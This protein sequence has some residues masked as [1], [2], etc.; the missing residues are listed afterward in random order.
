LEIK[1]AINRL[2]FLI[3]PPPPAAPEIP[4]ISNPAVLLQELS[5]KVAHWQ[6]AQ[7]QDI[8]R[9]AVGCGALFP[10]PNADTGN[11]KINELTGVFLGEM[12][13][14]RDLLIQLNKPHTSDAE[15]G[16]LVNRIV[17]S[18]IVK[19]EAG[20]FSV[21]ATQP[22]ATLF[23]ATFATDVNTDGDRNLPLKKEKIKPLLKELTEKTIDLLA[24]GGP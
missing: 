23:F 19:V 13:G 3:A 16:L 1:R 11:K 21:V 20:I 12:Q 9:M 24:N 18:M 17:R 14:Y 8:I 10:I 2:D 7:S 15:P 22:L 5:Q 6:Q 4:L